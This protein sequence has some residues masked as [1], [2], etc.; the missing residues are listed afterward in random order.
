MRRPGRTKTGAGMCKSWRRPSLHEPFLFA[1]FGSW[2]GGYASGTLMCRG[3]RP[4]LTPKLTMGLGAVLMLLGVPAFLAESRFMA[5][6]W[7]CLVLFGYSSWAANLLSLPADLFTSSEVARVTGLSGT[8]RSIGGML[9][10][11]AIGWLVQHLSYGPVF[12][13][14]SAMIVCAALGVFWL[15]PEQRI[16]SNV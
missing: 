8:A 9:F 5:V 13:L 2:F 12:F 6:W 15:V 7:I 14:A 16:A 10:T 1:A 3:R 11:L 4:V